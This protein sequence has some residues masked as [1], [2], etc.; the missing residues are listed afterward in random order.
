MDAHELVITHQTNMAKTKYSIE[1]VPLSTNKVRR[2]YERWRY[3]EIIESD[4]SESTYTI[5]DGKGGTH[6]GFTAKDP[7]LRKRSNQTEYVLDEYRGSHH[8][9]GE[10]Q[11]DVVSELPNDI[12]QK[13]KIVYLKLVLGDTVSCPSDIIIGRTTTIDRNYANSFD[14]VPKTQKV[15]QRQPVRRSQR[16]KIHEE[17]DGCVRCGVVSDIEIHHIIPYADGGPTEIENLAPLCEEC[18]TKAHPAYYN[19]SYGYDSIDEFW[20]WVDQ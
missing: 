15:F 6:Y 16:E 14:Y 10:L 18:H 4:Q 19:D 9:F 3:P 7:E 8:L 12:T 20:R 11:E 17:Y 13:E 2:F 5:I 1:D